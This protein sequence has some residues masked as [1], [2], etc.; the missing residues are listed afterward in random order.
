MKTI[1]LPFSDNDTGKKNNENENSIT[2]LNNDF[3]KPN[4][5]IDKIL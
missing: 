5:G 3:E 4:T 1:G 2:I